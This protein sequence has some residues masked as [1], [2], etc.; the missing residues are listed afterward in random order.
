M[1]SVPRVRVRK[2]EK[3]KQKMALFFSFK[4]LATNIC[5]IILVKTNNLRS[6]AVFVCAD[7][8]VM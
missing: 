7:E 8:H 4:K 2:N 3:K 6:I 1:N 5:L